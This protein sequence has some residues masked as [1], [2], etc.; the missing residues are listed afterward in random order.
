MKCS[1]CGK[2]VDKL[3][4]PT[5]WGSVC[6]TCLLEVAAKEHRADFTPISAKM[7]EG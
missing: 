7:Y 4:H 6:L 2:E 3:H 5:E 1:R